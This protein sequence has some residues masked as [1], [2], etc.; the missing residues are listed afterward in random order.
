MGCH[1]GFLDKVTPCA[2]M[3]KFRAYNRMVPR[4]FSKRELDL[5]NSDKYQELMYESGE[6]FVNFYLNDLVFTEK[7]GLSL[8]IYSR[9]RGRGK[10]NL[11]HK[12]VYEAVK[13]FSQDE[14]YSSGRTYAFEHIDDFLSTFTKF[15]K[16]DAELPWQSTWYVLDDLGHE[17]R[18]AKWKKGVLLDALQR[19]MQYRRNRGLPT[20]ITSNYNPDDL[21]IIYEGE[22]NSLF[23]IQYDGTLGGDLFRAVHVGG[24]E[25]FRLQVV[26]SA[27]CEMG[28]ELK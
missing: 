12:L 8:Y 20:I 2:C 3:H 24:A 21:S 4:G 19:M 28:G 6:A 23:E 1:D 27:W 15:N 9:E 16:K 26:N 14:Y 5:I 22:L 7:N 11:A 18:A 10:T 17:D 13:L 25:D